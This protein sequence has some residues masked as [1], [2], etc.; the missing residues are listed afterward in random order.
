MEAVSSNNMMI[1][2][3]SWLIAD[4]NYSHFKRGE[5]ASFA[6]AFDP[7]NSQLGIPPDWLSVN[8][9][10]VNRTS[11]CHVEGSDYVLTAKV[12]HVF[13]NDDGW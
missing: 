10:G 2:L 11:I 8:P 4:G 12:T 13:D 1:G 7:A 5:R 9:P 3:S 6:L